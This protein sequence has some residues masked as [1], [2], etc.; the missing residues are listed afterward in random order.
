MRKRKAGI[1]KYI[2]IYIY[3]YMELQKSFHDIVR[4]PDSGVMDG[5]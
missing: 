4:T 1:Y 2:Y 5:K 3:I